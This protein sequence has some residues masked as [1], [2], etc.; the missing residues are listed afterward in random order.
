MIVLY[1]LLSETENLTNDFKIVENLFDF[2]NLNENHELFSIKKK[3][4]G[5]YKNETLE[6]IWVDE[7][8][9]LRGGAYSFKWNDKNT[10]ILKNIS[11]FQSKNIKFEEKML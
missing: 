7:F 2:S 10:K 3:V 4:V 9:A 11:K 6:L 5:K 1:L 8:L